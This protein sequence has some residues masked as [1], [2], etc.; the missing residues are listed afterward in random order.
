MVDTLY[1]YVD[2]AVALSRV[3]DAVRRHDPIAMDTEADSLHHYF[4][5]VCLVQLS[6]GD[7]N[8]I[9]DPLA[10]LDLT[11]LLE[12]LSDKTIIFHGADYDLHMLHQ[13][14]GFRPRRTPFDTMLAAQMLG[15]RELSLAALV[16]RYF[17]VR[18][19]KQGQKADWSKR[20]IAE[21]LLEYASNDTRYL[22]ALKQMLRDELI[23]L[24]RL[25]WHEEACLQ[26]VR[27]ALQYNA[28]KNPD[29]EWRIKGSSTLEPASLAVLKGL[30]Y[31][32]DAEARRADVPVFK[33]MNNRALL[34]LSV[35]AGN[36]RGAR[37]EDWP[38]LPKRYHPRRL[39]NLRAAL[40]QARMAPVEAR[41]AGKRNEQ[42]FMREDK[43]LIEA[44]REK[45]DSVAAE[46]NLD[47]AILASRAILV[48]I[49]RLKP[50]RLEDFAALERFYQWQ[51][52]L[53]G[54]AFIEAI[55]VHGAGSMQD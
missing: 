27:T 9:I 17:C 21:H 7:K 22:I 2:S 12:A 54:E 26:T 40:H 8:Y 15:H 43:D 47:P 28:S 13:F 1:D 39:A 51:V 45:R 49:S 50:R 48:A 42:E 20:P 41:Y 4:E 29:S 38:G 53:L 33:V 14:Y 16:E 35:W 55:K 52:N 5:K 10:G 19:A 37:L 23:R 36:D 18:L 44:L 11:P 31:W 25:A 30:W 46:L 34:D 32:R 24:D 3:L 6:A